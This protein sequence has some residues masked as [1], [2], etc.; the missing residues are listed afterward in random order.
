MSNKNAVA[1]LAKLV[2]PFTFAPHTLVITQ[3][4]KR[5]RISQSTIEHQT[6]NIEEREYAQAHRTCNIPNAN[7]VNHAA[8]VSKCEPC[9]PRHKCVE[10]LTPS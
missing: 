6:F 7:R 1:T 3:A 9:E 8:D 4:T 2:A 10:N 5:F